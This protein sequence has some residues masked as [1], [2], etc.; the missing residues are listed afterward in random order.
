MEGAWERLIRAVKFALTLLKTEEMPSDVP[1][2]AI[3][4]ECQMMVNSRPLTD[5]HTG[6]E[7]LESLTPNHFLLRSSGSVKPVGNITDNAEFL[8]LEWK[9][10]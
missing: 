10:Q 4:T 6:G 3:L 2:L 9:R 7:N 5:V 1:M 8:K